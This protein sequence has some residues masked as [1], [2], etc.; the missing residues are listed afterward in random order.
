LPLFPVKVPCSHRKRAKNLPQTSFPSLR[1]VKPANLLA[2]R[3]AA[4][5]RSAMGVATL[6]MG[7]A[8]RA[9]IGR[10]RSHRDH[11]NVEL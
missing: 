11:L 4:A 2:A 7:V 5:R 9:F 1:S 10:G 6:A 3:L 8:M